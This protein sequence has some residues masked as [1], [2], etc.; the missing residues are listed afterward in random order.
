MK[1]SLLISTYNWPVALSLCLESIMA[2]SVYPDEIVIADDGSGEDT[3]S[4]IHHWREVAPFPIIHI[5]QPDNGFQLAQIRNKAIV[6]CSSDYIIQI[7]GDLILH[8]YFIED[9]VRFSQSNSFVRASRIY[10]DKKYSQDKM[11]KMSIQ[12]NP[13]SRGVSNFFSAFRCS[14]FWKLFETN[15]KAKGEEKWEIHGCNMAY[16]RKD[17]IRVNG[18]NEDFIGWGPEDKEFI[19]RLMNAGLKKR[20]L[21]FGGIVFHLWHKINAKETILENERIFEQTKKQQ[22]TYCI[23]GLDKYV[24]NPILA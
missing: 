23:N 11:D 9:H 15:Y 12:I 16:W 17:A 8:P 13:F 3:L 18:Y 4:V 7:D 19:A 6:S 24:V 1:V 2:Q 5:W 21:K 14:L 10:L 22:L 20:F